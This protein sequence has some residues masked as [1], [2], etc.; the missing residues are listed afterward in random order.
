M[1]EAT[2][3]LEIEYDVVH[4]INVAILTLAGTIGAK[5]LADIVAAGV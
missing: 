5:V 1:W 4:T 3:C 2:H